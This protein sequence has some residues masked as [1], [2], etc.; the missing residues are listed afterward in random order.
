[1]RSRLLVFTALLSAIFL[2]TGCATQPHRP[3][4]GPRKKKR[5]ENVW[6]VS[7]GFHSSIAMRAKDAPPECRAFDGK[8]RYFVIG[9]GGRDLYMMR[10]V[11]PWQWFTSVALPTPSAMHIIPIRTSLLEECPC[12]EII[13]FD[14]TPRG[15]A[16]LRNRIHRAFA[17]DPYGQPD[18]AGPGKRESSKFFTGSEIYYLPK[19]CNLWAATGLRVAGVPIWASVA[20]IADNLIWQC[21]RHGRELSYWRHPRDRL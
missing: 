11:K 2:F 19:T 6:L 14:V 20:L 4:F 5:T 9:W 8:A 17:R 3:L 16:H 1:M 12:S 13:E 7:N 10:D 21:R 18:I 15:V